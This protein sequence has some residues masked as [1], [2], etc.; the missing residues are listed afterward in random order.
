MADKQES[1]SII[2][3]DCLVEGTL[4]VQGK[5]MVAGSLKGAIIGNTVVTV[6]GSHVDA[7]AKVR[8][9]IIGG[10]FEGDITVYENLRILSTGV[11]SGKI[12]CKSLI[13]EAGGKL[14]GGVRPLDPT[15]ELHAPDTALAAENV[16]VD[17]VLPQVEEDTEEEK[18]KK[19]KD[20]KK[21]D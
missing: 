16:D 5:L 17:Q 21:S 15:E 12:T 20:P 2:D 9:L 1:L 4:N 13:L 7:P 19:K 14:D 6:K 10:E 3:E 8:E 18:P 11:F